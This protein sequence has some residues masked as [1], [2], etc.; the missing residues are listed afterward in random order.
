[1]AGLLFFSALHMALNAGLDYYFNNS[2]YLSRREARAVQELQNYII[3]KELTPYD[4]QELSRWVKD[5]TVVY[6]EIYRNNRLLYA[7]ENW[8]D[9]ILYETDTGSYKD[10]YLSLIHI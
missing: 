9:T 2:S 1:M 6:L 10:K 3:Q 5:E 7:S 8:D 4:S